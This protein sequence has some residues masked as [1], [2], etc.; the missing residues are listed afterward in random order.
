MMWKRKSNE[1][2]VRAILEWCVCADRSLSLKELLAT[3]KP[4]FSGILDLHKTIQSIC[5]K[6]GI[7]HYT[8]SEYLTSISNGRFR[9][10]VQRVHQKIFR[11]APSAL[12]DLRWRLLRGQ[13]AIESTEPFLFYAAAN[14]PYH[15]EHSHVSLRDELDGLVEFFSSPAVLSWIHLLALQN[16]IEILLRA[17]KALSVLIGLILEDKDASTPTLHR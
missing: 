7:L 4:E 11:K 16:R 9:V 10:N 3:L 8:A 2:L 17:A 13:H 6:I 12:E 5:G 14:W 15:L 1:S